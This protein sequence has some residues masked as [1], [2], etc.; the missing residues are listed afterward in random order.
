[1]L[2]KVVD[3]LTNL[4]QWNLMMPP[5]GIQHVCFDQI[6]E[7]QAGAD[8]IRDLNDGSEESWAR[9]R[10]ILST[11]NPRSQR[12]RRNQKI[13]RSFGEAVRSLFF[14]RFL[15]ELPFF[16]LHASDYALGVFHSQVS[17]LILELNHH[18]VW[19]TPPS[20]ADQ[21]CGSRAETLFS[22][23]WRPFAHRQNARIPED[24]RASTALPAN[25]P[26]NLRR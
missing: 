2:T 7:R 12:R 3:G 1:M 19:G 4:A 10:G 20:D 5:D 6:H 23:L 24:C 25:R 15:F 16:Q 9:I 21:N 26:R 13:A 11:R 18:R 8:V 14:G 22:S 17:V